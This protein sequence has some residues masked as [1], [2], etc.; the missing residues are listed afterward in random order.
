MQDAFLTLCICSYLLGQIHASEEIPKQINANDTEQIAN[1]PF[2][3]AI[4][5]LKAKVP[6]SKKQFNE[7]DKKLRFRAFT[8]AKLGLATEIETA[9]QIL[10]GALQNGESYAQ[11]WEQLKDVLQ[12]NASFNAGY[13]ETVFRTNTQSAYTAGKLQK[14]AGTGVVAYQLMVIEDSRTSHICKHLLKESGYGVALPVTHPFWQKYGFPP[15]H[16]NCR[17]SINP[18]YKSQ[19]GK[20]GYTVDNPPLK[21]FAKF[22]PQADFGGNPLEKGNWWMLTRSQME[23]AI[24]YRILNMFNREENVFA[25]YDSVWNDYNRH[26][27]KNGGWYDLYKDPP[28]DWKQNKEI[29]ELLANNGYKVKVIP[30][31]ENIK[32][33]YGVKWTNPDILL[34]GSL[35]DIKIVKDSITSRLKSAKDQKVRNAV[36]SIPDRFSELEIQNAFDNW[37]HGRLNVLYIYKGKLYKK[38]LT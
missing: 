31:L 5:F 3:E 28:D 34:N 38:E 30:T 33:L 10:I 20:T 13:W 9:K 12:E 17:T 18:I 19:L 14:Y 2:K 1:V 4:N 6:L 35:T 11:T 25:D 7:L 22:K 23:Q 32:T 21:H 37:K 26:D 27:G 29:V 8:M 24:K 16:F 36:V 15:Y